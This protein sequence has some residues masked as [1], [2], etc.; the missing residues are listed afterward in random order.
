M[1][2]HRPG[3]D[4]D[5]DLTMIRIVMIMFK[6]MV[7]RGS[8]RLLM[9]MMMMVRMVMMIMLVMMIIHYLVERG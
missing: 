2:G 1:G 4:D 5:E 7:E 3:E 8:L 9:L 6:N